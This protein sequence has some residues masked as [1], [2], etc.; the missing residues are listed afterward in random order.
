M[1]RG[2]A[3]AFMAAL[4]HLMYT[5]SCFG[6]ISTGSQQQD[7]Q[8]N[9]SRLLLHLFMNLKTMFGNVA[10]ASTVLTLSQSVHVTRD[11]S[12]LVIIACTCTCW[13]CTG[14]DHDLT[15]CMTLFCLLF[16]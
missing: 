16:C 2:R 1:M 5:F 8:N 12:Q 7:L 11:V 9:G 14:S 3:Y 6:A 10:F 15:Y 13:S 4:P